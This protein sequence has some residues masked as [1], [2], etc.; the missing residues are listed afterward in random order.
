MAVAEA[1]PVAVSTS[2]LVPPPVKLAPLAPMGREIS[3]KEQ[4]PDWQTQVFPMGSQ[5]AVE[6]LAGT[7]ERKGEVQRVG[8]KTRLKSIEERLTSI[9]G[10][11]AGILSRVGIFDGRRSNRASVACNRTEAQE[12]ARREERGFDEESK[13]R[14]RTCEEREVVERTSLKQSIF[15]TSHSIADLGIV[16]KDGSRA[17]ESWGVVELGDGNR[18]SNPGKKLLVRDDPDVGLSLSPVEELVDHVDD[19]DGIFDSRVVG[20]DVNRVG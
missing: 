9:S 20:G 2:T 1:D 17:L 15:V 14:P 19:G 7:G 8:N 11:R 12:S 10:L 3:V 16:R 5:K 13:T 4:S 18:I 6:Q